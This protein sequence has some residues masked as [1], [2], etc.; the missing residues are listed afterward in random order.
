MAKIDTAKI[1]NFDAL[2]EDAKNAILGME[3]ADA[4][5]MSLFVEKSVLDKKASEAAELS[6][7]LKARMTEEEVAKAQATAAQKELEEKYAALLKESTVNKYKAKYI[8]LGYDEALAEETAKAMVD[9][10]A[11]KVF[12]NG[13]KFKAAL[14]KSIKADILKGTPRPDGAGGVKPSVTKEQFAA[15]GYTDRAKLYQENKEL[16]NELLNGGNK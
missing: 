14:E 13:E 8:S 12:A 11:E 5:D 9:G 2:P 4:P 15:M 10:D 3:F 6:R 1:P 16:Y 7:Q